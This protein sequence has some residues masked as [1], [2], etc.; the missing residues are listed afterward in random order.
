MKDLIKLSING[1]VGVNCYKWR[2]VNEKSTFTT[3]KL[4]DY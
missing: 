3:Q 2:F 4:Q 1:E